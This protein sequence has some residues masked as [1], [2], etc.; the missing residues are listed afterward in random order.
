M[1]PK[2]FERGGNELKRSKREKLISAVAAL[3]VV[4]MAASLILP[5]LFI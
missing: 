3:L 4:V 5:Y 1:Y 2:N